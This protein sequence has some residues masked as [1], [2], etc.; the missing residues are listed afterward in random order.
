MIFTL[1][2]ETGWPERALLWE[3]PFSRLL[4]YYHA[5]LRS[6]DLWTVPAHSRLADPVDLRTAVA[7]FDLSEFDFT[8][9][10]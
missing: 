1:A 9:E 2:K 6:H 10:E 4:H 5:A 7:A 8:E 3:I